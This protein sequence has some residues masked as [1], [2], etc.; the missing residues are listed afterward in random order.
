MLVAHLEPLAVFQFLHAGDEVIGNFRV[1]EP[2]QSPPHRLLVIW[3]KLPQRRHRHLSLLGR[4]QLRDSGFDFGHGAHAKTDIPIFPLHK[5]EDG[6]RRVA[7]GSTVIAN[8]G[9]W[10]RHYTPQ[11]A[12]YIAVSVPTFSPVTVN[13][14]VRNAILSMA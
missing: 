5:S 2:E 12:E 6:E 7:A 8:R 13:R 1:F 9:E 11:G 4:W 3:I 14:D 10:V